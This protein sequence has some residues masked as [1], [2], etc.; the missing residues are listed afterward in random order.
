MKRCLM[1][2]GQCPHE[3]TRTVR[4][5]GIGDRPL[6]QPHAEWIVAQG[7]GRELEPNAYVPEWRGRLTA[8]DMTGRVLA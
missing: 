5:D 7:M 4:I 3:A 8:K 1:A 2:G 6:C